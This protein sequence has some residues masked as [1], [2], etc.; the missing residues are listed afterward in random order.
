MMQAAFNDL[1]LQITNIMNLQEFINGPDLQI[2]RIIF[3]MDLLKSSLLGCKLLVLQLIKKRKTS[4]QIQ[5]LLEESELL[6]IL[7]RMNL[8]QLSKIIPQGIFKQKFY[9]C[10]SHH[11]YRKAFEDTAWLQV[12]Q[13]AQNQ[14]MLAIQDMDNAK[15]KSAEALKRLIREELS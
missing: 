12:E 6:K 8:N 13:A 9:V 4:P 5:N 11:T 1:L 15:S 3:T 14:M 7:D 2:E 10:V